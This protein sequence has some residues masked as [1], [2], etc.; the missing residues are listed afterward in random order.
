M[1]IDRAKA[2]RVRMVAL[3]VDGVT[4]VVR[5]R[6]THDL[7]VG[8]FRAVEIVDALDYDLIAEMR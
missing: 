1:E 8:A 7:E 4:N 5:G 3:D 6:G 2:S